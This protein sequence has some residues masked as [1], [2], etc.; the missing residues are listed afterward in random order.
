MRALRDVGFNRIR[1]EVLA[2]RG[3]RLLLQRVAFST[4]DGRE[5]TTL[6]VN[7]WVN[8]EIVYRAVFDEDA[9]D[10]AVAELEARYLAG[11]GAP[12]RHSSN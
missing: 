2:V 6:G 9:L 5:L 4:D 7:E 1:S 10:D 11:E 8:G 12:M 3:D